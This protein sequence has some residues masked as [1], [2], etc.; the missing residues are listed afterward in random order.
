MTQ[1]ALFKQWEI[2][3][4]MAATRERLK[5][6]NERQQAEPVRRPASCYTRFGR[7]CQKY[8]ISAWEKR[9]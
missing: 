8:N 7:Y 4:P 6:S 5:E 1:T 2:E 3:L 9:R